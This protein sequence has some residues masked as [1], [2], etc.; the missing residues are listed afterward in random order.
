MS[1]AVI[2]KNR[3]PEIFFRAIKRE[4]FGKKAGSGIWDFNKEYFKRSC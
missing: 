1:A 4:S 3:M 2:K